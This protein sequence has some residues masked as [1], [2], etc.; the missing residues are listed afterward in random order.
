M[1]CF[2]LKSMFA[3]TTGHWLTKGIWIKGFSAETINLPKKPN[4]S[5]IIDTGPSE[6]QVTY[7][8]YIFLYS[9]WVE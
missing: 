7:Q 9:I 6:P 3:Y 8:G 4:I 5:W 2:D 1:F